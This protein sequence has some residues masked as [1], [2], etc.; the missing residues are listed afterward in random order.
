MNTAAREGL[1][2]TFL[3][4]ASYRCAIVS[5]V[6]PDEFASRFGYHAEAG[7]FEAGLRTLLDNDSWRACGAAAYDYVRTTH[8][9]DVVIDRH[10]QAYRA[11]MRSAAR[12]RG[13]LED[14]GPLPRVAPAS[15]RS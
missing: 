15:K 12:S 13:S 2:V 10:L 7:D 8:A 9:L 3:E 11:L 4:A 14:R 1:P 5:Q 6:N